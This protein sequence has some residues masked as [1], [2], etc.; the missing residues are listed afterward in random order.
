MKYKDYIELERKTVKIDCYYFNSYYSQ[1]VYFDS[2]FTTGETSIE[3]V[4][5]NAFKKHIE[6]EKEG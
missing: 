1:E 3:F 6:G 5:G 2:D 4:I